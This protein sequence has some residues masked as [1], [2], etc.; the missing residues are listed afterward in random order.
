MPLVVADRVRE[1]TTTTGTG[2]ITLAGA[3]TGYQSFSAVGNGNTTYY[4]INAGSQ[5]EVGIGTYLGAGPTLSR[6]TVLESSNSGSLV[7]FS[8]GTKDVFITYPA[9]KSI[10]DGYGLLPVANGGTGQSSYT[11]G[12][13][14][15]GNTTGNT[16]TKTTLTAGTNVTITNGSGAITINATDA[17]VGTV[18]S[19]GGTGTVSGLTLTG[20]VTTSGN[21]TLGGTLAV[22]ASDFASQTAKTFLAAPNASAGVPSF[23]AIIPADVPTLNQNTTGT[24]SNVTGTV[25][26]AN[27]GTGATTLTSGYLLKGNGTSAVS[28]SVVYDTGTN[29][30]IGTT[31]PDA[32]LDIL[33]PSG[34]QIRLRTA[35]TE[36]YRIGRSASTGYLDFYGSQTGYTGYTFG[37]VNG[38]RMRIDSGGNVG[39]G[40]SSPG[41]KLDVNGGDIYVRTSGRVLTDVVQGYSGTSTPLALRAAR[42]ITLSTADTVR[43]TIDINGNVGIGCTPLS[44]TKLQ[45]S[46]GT[47]RRFSVFLNGSDNVF[48]YLTDAGNWTDTFLNGSPVRF[49]IGGTERMRIDTAGLVGI[50]T[51]SP[52]AKLNVQQTVTGSVTSLLLSRTTGNVAD[53]QSIVW[54]QNDL[55]NLQYSSIAAV[56]DSAT[57]GSMLFKT[58]SGG[59]NTERM[60]IN[61]SGN[62]G[63]GTTAPQSKMEIRATSGGTVFNA[64]TLSNY[65]G[66][67]VNTGVALY[68]DPNGAG[69]LARA[70]SIQSVQAT[71][72]NYADLRFFTAA[73]DTPAER[74]RITTAGLVGIGTSAPGTKLDVSGNIRLSAGTP[75]IEF[76]NGGGMIYGPA[77]NTLAFATGGGPSAPQEKMRIAANGNLLVGTTSSSGKITV[78]YTSPQTGMA[79]VTTGTATHS[80]VTFE[81]GNGVVGTINTSGSSTAYNTSS[82]ARLKHDII[83]APDAASLIDAI[84]VRS[85]KWNA[86]NSEQRYGFV[87]QELVTVAPEA[88]SQPAD[89]EEMM[90]VDYSKLVPMLI[91][92]VQSLRARVA[93]LEG[94]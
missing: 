61:S 71:S 33:G 6:D 10:S 58:A 35:E 37:G 16:L 43:A 11:D 49:G 12:Q 77:G 51:S 81:N 59:T 7:N 47:D 39:I 69:S 2:T 22:T 66:A 21:L 87:A 14:L 92:E 64:L 3:V 84:Q 17:F 27:G 57:S 28:A 68:F 15:I 80:A 65:V 24:A 36:E 25:A 29:V 75:N 79:F 34:D 40:T 83:D 32:K 94:N 74:M 31:S 20:T 93:Q 85:F 72:G 63:V 52:G 19:V 55:S 30:G 50:G 88:V 41:A 48:G 60:R 46:I 8:A 38:E 86:D 76:N 91:K 82:D 73:S 26:V 4:T 53:E 78:S 62:I 42:T 5:W 1:T 70:A 56:V 44:T 89:P 13:L 18:T 23:R 67:S 9:E 45:T 90:G 54:Q